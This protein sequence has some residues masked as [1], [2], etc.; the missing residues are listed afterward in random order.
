MSSHLK[1]LDPHHMITVGEEGFYG[2]GSPSEPVNPGTGWAT[3]TGQNFT[4]NHA[5]AS[6]DFAAIHLW[7]DNWEVMLIADKPI[8]AGSVCQLTEGSSCKELRG[9]LN[10]APTPDA[11]IWDRC[12]WFS[13]VTIKGCTHCQTGPPGM[14]PCITCK[15][16]SFAQFHICWI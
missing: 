3:I 8:I 11:P 6:I 10:E 2:P 4:A 1:Q 13:S 14:A 7:P 12:G 15:F 16:L 5:P 9:S